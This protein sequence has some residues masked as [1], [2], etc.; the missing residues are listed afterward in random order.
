ME[1]APSLLENSEVRMSR[2]L[3]T[4]TKTQMAKIMVQ[5][6]RPSRSSWTKSVRSSSGRTVLGKAT[7]EGCIWTRLG[8][9]SNLE[10]VRKPWG[11][12]VFVTV[13][14]RY[15]NWLERNKILTQCGKYS[16]G[17]LTWPSQ[18]HSLT[19]S[20]LGCTQRECETSKDIVENYRNRFESRIS[21]GAKEKQSCSGKLDA[22]ISPWTN[23]MEGHAKKCVE[24]YCALANKTRQQLYKVSWWPSIQ[25]RR[26][27]IYWRKVK[28]M[29]SNCS[30]MTFYGTSSHQMDQS[31]WQ[32]VGSFD[33]LRS[34]HMW[35]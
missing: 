21:A 31:L 29:L 13:C 26:I 35:I 11:C 10:P 12:A 27:G 14:G 9:S 5:H 23:D 19:M 2:H 4:S 8:E 16:W 20:N 30:E 18:H 7:W 22:D 17:T 34:S 28:A 6:G 3:D 24:R 33:F 15:K 25:R 32:T 1:D